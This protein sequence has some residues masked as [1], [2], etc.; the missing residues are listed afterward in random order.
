MISSR[1]RLTWRTLR[2]CSERPFLCASSSSSTTMGRKMSCSSKRKIAVGSCMSTFVSSTKRRRPTAGL[3]CELTRVAPAGEGSERLRRFKNFLHV[4]RDLHSAPFLA[5]HPI[6][7]DEERAWVYSNV[8][9]A[10]E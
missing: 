3:T 6:R 8:L 4:A 7:I 2:D 5:E 9:D 10:V 1:K